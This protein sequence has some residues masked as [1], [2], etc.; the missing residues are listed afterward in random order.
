L[1]LDSDVVF[2]W[3]RRVWY[4][5]S[6]SPRLFPW[7]VR[8]QRRPNHHP[9]GP[10]DQIVI[11]GFP[12]SANTF[13]SHAFSF[14][15]P[16]V[17]MSH[18]MHAPANI[19][20]AVR[21]GVPTIVVIRNPADAVLSE[22]IR[23][24]RKRLRR[25]LTEWISYYT[26]VRRVVDHV[27]LAD[28]AVVTSDYAF[29]IAEVNRRFNTNFNLYHNSP[30]SD[31][32]VFESIEATGRAKGWTGTQLDLQVPRPSRQRVSHKAALQ[33]ELARPELR[34]LL[35]RAEALYGELLAVA[36]HPS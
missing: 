9:A 13:S 18:H 6:R 16:G 24:P 32:M 2:E 17:R 31:Q 10:D 28:F 19:L 25:A 7:M 5:L 27:V 11:D 34:G 20:L 33:A 15:N 23:E 29:V 14:A 26:L 3:S 30:E 8:A 35:E 4:P 21:H 1:V 12:R 36:P 22:V